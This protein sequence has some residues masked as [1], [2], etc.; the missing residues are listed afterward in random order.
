MKYKNSQKLYT[1]HYKDYK[2]A[3]YLEILQRNILSLYKP[4]RDSLEN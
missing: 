2:L 1:S 4:S 3:P